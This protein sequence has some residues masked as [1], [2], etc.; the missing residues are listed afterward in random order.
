[1]IDV[2]EV[3]PLNGTL[4]PIAARVYS[5]LN[6]AQRTTYWLLLW[7]LSGVGR[8]AGNNELLSYLLFHPDY[9]R[10]QFARGEADAHVAWREYE[11]QR[12][13]KKQDTAIDAQVPAP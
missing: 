4:S 1:L 3:A 12:G 11:L 6:L 13:G 7:L 10:E 5:S 9:F 8:G 2:I